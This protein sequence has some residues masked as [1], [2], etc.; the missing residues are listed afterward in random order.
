[1][2]EQSVVPIRGGFV[3]HNTI[4]QTHFRARGVTGKREHCRNLSLPAEAPHAERTRWG[5]DRLDTMCSTRDAIAICIV[6]VFEGND[7]RIGNRLNHSKR[8]R[9][10]SDAIAHVICNRWQIL[11]AGGRHGLSLQH[12]ATEVLKK[13][14]LSVS[15]S[16]EVP[17]RRRAPTTNW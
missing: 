8:E 5:F 1:M 11:S 15:H 14:E 10:W 2:T 7:G 16:C 3:W 12:R 17:D 6:R 13:I 4:C 9:A